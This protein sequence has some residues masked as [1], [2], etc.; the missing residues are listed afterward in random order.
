M[1]GEQVVVPTWSLCRDCPIRSDALCRALPSGQLSHVS[2]AVRRKRYRPGSVIARSGDP[3][4]WCAHVVAGVV[5]LTL[6]LPDG[7]Q[8]IVSLLF[9][10]D[11]LG[12]LFKSRTPFTAEAASVVELCC[13]DR[14]HFEQL[15]EDHPGMKQLFLEQTL[16][17][18]DAARD[19]MLLLGCKSAEERVATLILLIARRTRAARNAPCAEERPMRLDL[20]LSRMEMAEFLGLRTETISRQLRRLHAAGLI[21]MPSPRS[22]TV[23]DLRALERTVEKDGT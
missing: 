5:K 7:R 9:P 4:D 11:F 10:S 1:E 16:D 20:P 18:V 2:R 6:A 12:R 8:Q 21:D 15:L 22:I 3:V 17:A 19:W 14:R 13:F 23:R